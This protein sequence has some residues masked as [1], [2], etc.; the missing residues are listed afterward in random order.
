MQDFSMFKFSDGSAERPVYRKGE[1]PAVV[2]MH[3]LPGMIPECVDLARRIAAASFTVYMPL[4]FGQPD[5]PL[6]I[7]KTVGYTAQLCI[8]QEFYCFAKHQSSPITN[9]LRALCRRAHQECG[10]RGV[11]VIGMCLTG[12]FVLSLMAD[13]VVIAPVVA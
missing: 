7:P 5:E 4:L 1:G 2:L 3:E 11:G 13:N 10:D 12:S 9:W 6:S 8:S